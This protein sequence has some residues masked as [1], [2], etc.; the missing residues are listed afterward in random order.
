M[1]KSL[2]I[3][4]LISAGALFVSC[5][6]ET[7]QPESSHNIA[8]TAQTNS[9]LIRYFTVQTVI[10]TEKVTLNGRLRSANRIEL[11]PEVQGVINHTPKPF[12]EGISYQ[13]GDVIIE[14]D[15]TETRYQL[16]SSRSAFIKLIS[17]LMADIRLDYP[18]ALPKYEDWF[19]SLDSDRLVK[20]VPD[21][22]ESITRFLQSKGIFEMY[23]SIK[24]AEER[25]DKFTIRAPIT[26]VLSAA[27]A[28]VGQLVGPQFHLGTLVTSSKFILQASVNP[29]KI[30]NMEPGTEMDVWTENQMQSYVARVSR[31]NPNINPATQQVTVYLEVLGD[32]LRE[33]MYLEGEFEPQGATE[34]AKIPKTSLMRSSKVIVKREGSLKEVPVDV[35]KIER[36]VLWVSGLE[37]GAEIVEDVTEPVGGL[38]TE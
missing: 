17:S 36:E 5:S 16:N 4:C 21:L 31:V 18:K 15:E 32:D 2:F 27:N 20:P 8:A 1:K 28:E 14:M 30:R 19:M 6:S 10:V 22:G 12:R 3:V 13:K 34:L 7:G 26:G 23:Y 25:L 24:S 35:E 33:G 9:G 29:D 11:F 38:I 37:N